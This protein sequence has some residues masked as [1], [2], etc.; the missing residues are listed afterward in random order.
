[1]S[2]E[3]SLHPWFKSKYNEFKYTLKSYVNYKFNVRHTNRTGFSANIISYKYDNW[4]AYRNGKDISQ[5]QKLSSSQGI[6]QYYQ[7]FTQSK[8]DITDKLS[9]NAGIH[10]IYFDLNKKHHIEPRAGARWQAF[11]KHAFSIA[12]GSHSQMQPLDIYFIQKNTNGI[13]SLPNKNLD[14]SEAQHLVFGYDY[15]INENMRLKVEPYYQILSNIAVEDSTYFA[16]I[17]TEETHGFDKVLVSKGE[18]TNYGVDITLE[19]FLKNGYY[20]LFTSSF[21]E[22]KYKGGDKIERN[23]LYNYNFV[24]NLLAGKEWNI[25]QN[26]LFGFSGRLYL[27]GGN[28]K[29]PVNYEQSVINKEVVYDYSK[30]YESQAPILYRFDISATYRINKEKLSHVIA[31]QINNALASP[32]LYEEIFDYKLNNVREVVKGEPFPS[33]SWKIEF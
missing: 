23:S 11:K 6:S 4:R 15:N 21:F 25:R 30:A 31:L 33:L 18:G 27:K 12:Y 8:F 32:T 20:F 9:L 16:I 26:N 24:T 2:D 22:A 28:R 17:N 1:M 10:S 7:F 14:F 13:A 3:L 29:T 5:L 19:R